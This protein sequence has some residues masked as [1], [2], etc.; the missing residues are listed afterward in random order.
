MGAV[1]T[2]RLF[3]PETFTTYPDHGVAVVLTTRPAASRQGL[4]SESQQRRH[5]HEQRRGNDQD[6]EA[7]AQGSEIVL[8]HNWM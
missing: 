2:V 4:R 7:L 8:H 5:C 1:W 3:S 6:R